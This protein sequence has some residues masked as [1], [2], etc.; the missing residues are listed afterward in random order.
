VDQNVP[1]YLVSPVARTSASAHPRSSRSSTP[2]PGTHRAV[3]AI[4]SAHAR[5]HRRDHLGSPSRYSTP[6]REAP[7]DAPS[8][9][10]C[11]EPGSAATRPPRHAEPLRR[12]GPARPGHLRHQE[13]P[14]ELLLGARILLEPS[15]PDFDPCTP[16]IAAEEGRRLPLCH[17]DSASAPPLVVVYGRP[18]LHV[19][20][21]YAPC[22]IP[23][24]FSHH[25]A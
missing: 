4:R 17:P 1:P 22:P 2:K 16:E 24:S 15:F 5:N 23:G 25:C 9:L 6:A 7:C 18:Q 21:T 10:G 14:Q 12:R 20:V 13:P 8:L 3:G 11:L 19:G